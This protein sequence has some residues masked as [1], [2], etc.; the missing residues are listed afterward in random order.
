MHIKE[1]TE[2]CFV[3]LVP[4]SLLMMLVYWFIANNPQVV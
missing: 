1:K 2:I 3:T 4:Y